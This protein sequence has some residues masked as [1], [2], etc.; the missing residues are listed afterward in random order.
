MTRRSFIALAS[1]VVAGHSV[2]AIAQRPAIRV[3]VPTVVAATTESEPHLAVDP[4][5]PK[6]LVAAAIVTSPDTGAFAVRMTHQTCSA[7]ASF[8]DGATWQRHDF[9]F[10]WCFDPWVVI[11]P[12][13]SALVGMLGK[14]RSFP[15]QGDGGFLVFRSADGGRTWNDEPVGLGRNHDHAT[16]AQDLTSATRR[17]WIYAL[18]HRPTRAADGHQRYGVWTARSRDGGKSFDDPVYVVV[19][20]LHNLPEMPVVLR[21]GTLVVS[22][23]DAAF[24]AD[25]GGTD[26]PLAY[27]DPHRAWVMRSADGG[28]SFSTPL[29]VTDAC[30]PPPDYR[31]SAFAADVTTGPFADH[32]YFAC[33][34]AGGGP[35]VVASSRD[36]G[37]TWAPVVAMHAAGTDSTADN[38]IP[39]IAVNDHGVV[40]VAWIDG[41]RLP[42][43]RC[44]QRVYFATSSDGGHT[45]SDGA[46]VATSSDCG[47]GGDY[48][49]LVAVPGGSFRLMWSAADG[50]R[51]RLRIVRIDAD[52]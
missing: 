16:M 50:N 40:G 38:R 20:N 17:G 49:G 8:D 51:S 13:G 35:I 27:L 37:E 18:S 33:R 19:N 14:H 36:R 45:F 4:G 23:V 5:N 11:T 30:C 25:S 12:D 39:G 10:T 32:L 44:R 6:H 26:R 43:R 47:T 9:T 42:D 3:G 28:S 29:F 7:F 34:R 41:A 15:Q 1:V 22:Y 31:L 48:F 52:Q 21:D 24:L 46:E 2:P